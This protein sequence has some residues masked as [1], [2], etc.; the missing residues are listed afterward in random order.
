MKKL[1]ILKNGELHVHVCMFIELER[2]KF[3]FFFPFVQGDSTDKSLGQPPNHVQQSVVTDHDREMQ[4]PAIIREKEAW[5]RLRE[6]MQNVNI[7]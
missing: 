6:H 5:K 4:L 1:Y 2:L 3:F 7:L